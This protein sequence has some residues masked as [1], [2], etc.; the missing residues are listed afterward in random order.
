MSMYIQ[1]STDKHLEG[2]ALKCHYD[3]GSCSAPDVLD[4]ETIKVAPGLGLHEGPV[5]APPGWNE[6]NRQFGCSPSWQASS[7]PSGPSLLAGLAESCLPAS[8]PPGLT[9]GP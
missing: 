6:P 3:T 9:Q 5:K 7:L 1:Q 8:G 4:T 2:N